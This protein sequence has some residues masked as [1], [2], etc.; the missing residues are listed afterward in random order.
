MPSVLPKTETREF[1]GQDEQQD[2]DELKDDSREE[3]N[4]DQYKDII[5][6]WL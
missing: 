3:K 1:E 4:L 2:V 6:K 5:I